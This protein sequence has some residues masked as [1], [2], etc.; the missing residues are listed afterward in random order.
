MKIE[1]VRVARATVSSLSATELKHRVAYDNGG[2]DLQQP[3]VTIKGG[4]Y[5]S[6]EKEIPFTAAPSKVCVAK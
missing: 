3:Q 5:T 4:D 6:P 1:S 2:V